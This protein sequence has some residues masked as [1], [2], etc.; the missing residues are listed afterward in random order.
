MTFT[1]TA[2]WGKK[3]EYVI[4]AEIN[5]LGPL[6]QISS[7]HPLLSRSLQFDV[8]TLILL[9]QIFISFD[10]VLLT[11]YR[12]VI[13]VVSGEDPCQNQ[14]V[15]RQPMQ[16]LQHAVPVRAGQPRPVYPNRGNAER[17]RPG[18]RT[19]PAYSPNHPGGAECPASPARQQPIRFIEF[20]VIRLIHQLD[21]RGQWQHPTLPDPPACPGTTTPS[22]TALSDAS[23]A[24]ITTAPETDLE[25]V[26]NECEG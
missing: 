4:D 16:P 7:K 26:Q 6:A 8:Y 22:G 12:L 25:N 11:G 20:W 24:R 9:H 3:S 14:Q 5:L 13:L 21:Q 23:N 1:S 15:C 18:R 17:T 2:A 19:R 10:A